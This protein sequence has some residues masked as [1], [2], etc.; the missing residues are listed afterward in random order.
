MENFCDYVVNL[1]LK[2]VKDL[3]IVYKEEALI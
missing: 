3:N 2:T 1:D